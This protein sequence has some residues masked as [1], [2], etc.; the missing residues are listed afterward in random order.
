MNP[1]F[2]VS[3]GKGVCACVMSVQCVSVKHVS[4]FIDEV[5]CLC[6]YM[7]KHFKC[8]AF[9]SEALVKQIFF[10]ITMSLWKAVPL[11]SL[12]QFLIHSLLGSGEQGHTE[13]IKQCPLLS[14]PAPH[15]IGRIFY[16]S[17]RHTVSPNDTIALSQY[18]LPTQ[19][20]KPSRFRQARTA[21]RLICPHC[22]QLI[23]SEN[24]PFKF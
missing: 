6:I 4:I 24:N 23:S 7:Y 12:L 19:K 10:S 9:C 22:R 5:S 18:C 21:H 2:L 17:R 15:P 16:G 13:D 3:P 1:L 11:V 14:Y 20:L 8:S